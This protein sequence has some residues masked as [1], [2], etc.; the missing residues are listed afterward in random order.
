ML[1]LF[2]SNSVAWWKHS[3][4]WQYLNKS[5]G[6]LEPVVM[7]PSFMQQIS[8]TEYYIFANLGWKTYFILKPT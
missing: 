8:S 7:T 4:N 5:D 3:I 2:R 6:A 1:L